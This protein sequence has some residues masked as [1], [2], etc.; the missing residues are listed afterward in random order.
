MSTVIQ[1]PGVF[2]DV[3]K[4]LDW[5]KR[6]IEDSEDVKGGNRQISYQLSSH[7]ETANERIYNRNPKPVDKKSGHVG[8]KQKPHHYFDEVIVEK[9]K[10]G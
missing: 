6:I 2:T 8:Y 7:H 5:I 3:R 10:V 1:E 4:H 9:L